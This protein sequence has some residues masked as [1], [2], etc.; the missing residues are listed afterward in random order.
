MRP[1]PSAAAAV[2]IAVLSAFTI[3]ITWQAKALEGLSLG[4]GGQHSA[5]LGKLAPAVVL[6]SLEGTPVSLADYHGK[7]RVV[8]TY[9]AS[10]C[11][12]CR[13]ELPALKAFY[14][15]ARRSGADFEVLA[16]NIDEYKDSAE[17]AAKEL[18]LPFPV[19]L[20]PHQKAAG[21]YGVSSIPALFVID[22][23]GRVTYTEVGFNLG[24]DFILA[25][26][27]GIDPKV[28]TK[29]AANDSG[30]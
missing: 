25:G 29:G 20:D 7:K 5:L 11:G 18:K 4:G 9:W 10:W 30:H 16:I 14:A 23:N 28:I 21:D 19:L 15:E 26:Q 13:M 17:G 27:L 3:W 24:M 2:G 1:R 6:P 8:L 12:P 22:T